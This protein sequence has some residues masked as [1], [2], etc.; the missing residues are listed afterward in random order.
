MERRRRLGGC[1]MTSLHDA[2]LDPDLFGRTFGGPTFANWRIVAKVLEGLPLSPEEF[3]FYRR[4]T[5]RSDAP[6]KP[7]TEG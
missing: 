7:F 1:G 3:E 2:M 5:G 6:S 4:I